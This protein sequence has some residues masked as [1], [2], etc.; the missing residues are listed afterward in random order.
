MELVD[1]LNNKHNDFNNFKNENSPH[2]NTDTLRSSP[3]LHP[4]TLSLLFPKVPGEGLNQTS[5]S[6]C[7]Q[8]GSFPFRSRSYLAPDREK[9]E[10]KFEKRPMRL[11]ERGW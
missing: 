2:I 8:V 4:P 6:L 10:N 5:P 1:S 11:K 3:S 7:P 9:Q